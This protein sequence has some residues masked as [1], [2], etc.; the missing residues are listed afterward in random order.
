MQVNEI[1]EYDKALNKI[2]II[3]LNDIYVPIR[4]QILEMKSAPLLN[5]FYGMIA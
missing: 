2:L 1:R 4:S 3:G 5:E